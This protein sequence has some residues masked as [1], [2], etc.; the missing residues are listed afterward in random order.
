MDEIL[1]KIFCTSAIVSFVSSILPAMFSDTKVSKIWL[2][3]SFV[4]LIFSIAVLTIS[5]IGL[6]RTA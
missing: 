2:K 1:L 4:C 3:I 6:I 5:A